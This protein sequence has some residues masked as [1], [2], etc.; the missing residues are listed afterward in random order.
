[1]GA[2]AKTKMRH[3][4]YAELKRILEGHRIQIVGD[5]QHPI[6]RT[7]AMDIYRDFPCRVFEMRS[8]TAHRLRMSQ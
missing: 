3:D 4:R 1:M 6:R 7:C 8:S 5:V 2:K